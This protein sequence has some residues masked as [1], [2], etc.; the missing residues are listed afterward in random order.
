MKPGRKHF[1][2]QLR[3]AA[4]G[5]AARLVREQLT[6]EQFLALRTEIVWSK[7]FE[8]ATSTARTE[9]FAYLDACVDMLHASGQL[10]WKHVH[11][12]EWV[13]APPPPHI[14]Y[15]DIDPNESR[16]VWAGSNKVFFSP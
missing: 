5:L 11:Q 13:E 9:L 15:R 7:A 3:G 8:R 6:H 4:Q 14:S 10:I 12:G 2:E 16:H 1:H